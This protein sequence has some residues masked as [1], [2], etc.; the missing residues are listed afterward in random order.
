MKI[1]LFGVSILR[2]TVYISFANKKS[3]PIFRWGSLHQ[4]DRGITG[5]LCPSF[6]FAEG[7]EKSERFPNQENVRIVLIWWTI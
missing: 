7:N 3:P 1:S 4:V 2:G 6:D 5:E